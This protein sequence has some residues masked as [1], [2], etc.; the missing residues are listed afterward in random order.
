MLEIEAV[1]TIDYNHIFTKYQG[2]YAKQHGI[3]ASY[4]LRLTI[5][6]N[7]ETHRLLVEEAK[8]LGVTPNSANLRYTDSPDGWQINLTSRYPLTVVDRDGNQIEN[9]EEPG[10]G[11]K[12]NVAFRIGSTRDHSK[13]VY[14]LTGVQLVKVTE[15]EYAPHVFGAFNDEEDSEF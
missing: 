6:K 12:A 5:P 13:L 10:N 4:Q 7:G 1:G 15:N 2:D 3:E 14:F 8:N 9:S 11:T